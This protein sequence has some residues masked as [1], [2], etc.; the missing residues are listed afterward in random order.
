MFYSKLS[1][2]HCKVFAKISFLRL[3]L[4][5]FITFNHHIIAT[6]SGAYGESTQNVVK[7]SQM[8]VF[9]LS[10]TIFNIIPSCMTAY[11]SDYFHFYQIH[12]VSVFGFMST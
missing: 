4:F 2:H 12:L 11:A 1:L 6:R 10:V 9:A 8:E 7:P 3:N 5:P